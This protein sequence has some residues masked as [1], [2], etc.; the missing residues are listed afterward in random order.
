MNIPAASV[1]T[2]YPPIGISRVMDGINA[3]LDCDV[4]F[5]DI[6]YYRPYFEDIRNKIESFSPDVI[7]FSAILTPTYAYLK[8]LSS[9]VKES[10]PNVIQVIGGEMTAIANLILLKTGIDFCVVGESEPI[11]SNLIRRLEADDFQP[12]RNIE[13]YVDIKGLAFLLNNVP[14]FTGYEKPDMENSLRQFNYKLL[15][16]F[17]NLGHY[18]HR[19]DGQY[20]QMRLSDSSKINYIVSLLYPHNR[21]KNMASVFASK[22]CVGK[23]TFCHRF[24][25]GYTVAEP[26][27]IINYIENLRKDLNV[28]FIMF[29]EENFGS[30]KS[31]TSKLVEYL[32]SSGLNWGAGAVRTTTVNEEI[33]RSWR[34]AGCV[35]INF[36]IESCSQKMLDVM[37]KRAAVS[38]NLQAIKLCHKYKIFTVIGS[39]MG[40]PGETEQTIQ[41]SIDNLSSVIPDDIGMP[42]ELYRNFVQ[43]VPG[44]P[45]YEYARG[46]GLIGKSIKDEERYIE[47]LCEV[48]AEEIEHYLNFTDYQKEEV[49]YWGYYIYLELVAAYIKKHGYI[50]VLKHHKSK[51][52]KAGLI[53]VLLPKKIRRLLLKYF[54]IIK[55]Y[56]VTG[57]LRVLSKKTLAVSAVN[58]TDVD[59]SLRKV[60]QKIPAVVREDEI[61]TAVLRQGR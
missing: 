54:I 37:E 9:S 15:S 59:L 30:H 14:Y 25:K 20:F 16:R 28:G 24:F 53:Y 46:I 7:G 61:S 57:M 49:A 8:K 27:S 44:T 47:S 42:Y 29:A 48:N 38:D 5:F 60:N 2:D 19:V 4:S 6:D 34:E 22:G 17:T 45:L 52:F 23:C 58:F 40:M 39:L 12:D 43:A 31:S 51:K 41:E 55:F 1:P 3:S 33:I 56:G 50:S 13:N 21:D 35:H 11:F 36:G 26:D 18:I 32:N 10:F